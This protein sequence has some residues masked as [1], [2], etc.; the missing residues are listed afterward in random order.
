MTRAEL[1]QFAAEHDGCCKV[2]KGIRGPLLV[3]PD[4]E[5]GYR[6]TWMYYMSDEPDSFPFDDYGI[7]P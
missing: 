6:A 4:E 1:E 3:P 5:I 7:K 2:V